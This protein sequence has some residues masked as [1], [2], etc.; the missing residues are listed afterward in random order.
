MKMLGRYLAAG[1]IWGS[2]GST[3]LA[4]AP[5]KVDFRRDVQPILKQNC[6][7]CHGPTQQM[8]GF[9]L[10]QQ[11]YALPNRIG[12]NG[13]RIVPGKSETSPLFARI[14]SNRLGPQMP[15]TE[16]LSK[17]DIATIQAWIDQGAEWPD[18]VVESARLAPDQKTLRWLEAL[19]K[20]DRKT[21]ETL[22]GADRALV[23]KPRAD[24]TTPLM[25]AALYSEPAVVRLLLDRGADP[26]L[27]NDAGATA[28][29][30][31]LEDLEK[32]RLLVDHGAD[33]NALSGDGRTPLM[34]AA[35]QFG[36]APVVQLLLDHGANAKAISPLGGATALTLAAPVGDET[37]FRTLLGHGADLKNGALAVLN[38]LLKGNCTACVDLI[39]PLLDRKVFSDALIAAPFDNVAKVQFL[40]DHGADVKAT[41]AAG[42]TALMMAAFSDLVP[43]QTVKLLIERGA[44]V[45]VRGPQN[46]TPLQFALRRGH[47][48]TVDLLLAAGAK[49]EPA[50]A[51]ATVKPSPAG[52]VRQAVERSVPL[53]QRTDVSFLKKSG[54]V[55]CHNNSLTSMTLS[56]AR[57]TGFTFD[58]ATQRN[59]LK[60]TDLY[61]ESWRDRM[62]QGVAIPG[63]L[64]TVNYLLLGLAADNY[65]AS[66]ATDAVARYLKLRQWPDGRWAIGT[67]RPPI[68]SSDIEATAVTLRV[69][70]AY[71]PLTQRA[72]YRLAVQQ[73]TAW[74]ATAVPK[75]NE[76]RAFQILG[77][78][79]GKGK[80]EAIR[81]AAADLLA[82]QRPDGGWSQ[83]SALESDAYASGQALVAL[84]ESGALKPSDPAYQRGVQFLLKSQFEDGSWHVKSRVI[85]IQPYFDNGFPHGEDQWISAA[86][87]NWAAMALAAATAK[88]SR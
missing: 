22:V 32:T 68:E 61:L 48:A 69:L 38:S 72:Q 26:N 52:S 42:R 51:S 66:E 29:M 34:I 87:T 15:P 45:N 37:V 67:N 3:V 21:V 11:R 41:N 53:L 23:N 1:V 31:A 30:W 63:G 76:D 19:R 83:L 47:T 56:T 33:V 77:L 50:P 40:L 16:A 13:V 85:K 35:N 24:G 17:E 39:V 44:D 57:R 78:A 79:W 80:Q 14:T 84:K 58:E 8:N 73:A 82:Q 81:K 4:Q 65:P 27:K 86:G 18:D 71:A 75:T 64:D 54:C 43:A 28:L 46:D 12:A 10:D 25:V 70:D 36:A 49:E 2:L 5:S 9:R 6:V 88:P 60:A 74:L 20:G 7:S 62:L 59:Q 55:S